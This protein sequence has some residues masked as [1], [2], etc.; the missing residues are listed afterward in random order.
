MHKPFEGVE[1]LE[2][3]YDLETPGGQHEALCRLGPT[4]MTYRA[5]APVWIIFCIVKLAETYHGLGRWAKGVGHL[6]REQGALA[7]VMVP[8]GPYDMDCHGYIPT[9]AGCCSAKGP[10]STV[11]FGR[12]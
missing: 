10:V 11:S 12:M 3:A 2:A 8:L 9:D 7:E 5:I 4:P 6:A 1:N